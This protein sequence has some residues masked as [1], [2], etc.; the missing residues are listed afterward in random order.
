M[1]RRIKMT[2]QQNN[3]IDVIIPCYNAHK[4]IFRCLCSI[5][6]Q[7]LKDDLKITLVNDCDGSD[8][9]KYVELFKGVL[10]IN[11]I[12]MEKN[13]G[14]GMARQTGINNTTNPIITFIDADDTFTGPYA[15]EVL[16]DALLE[17]KTHVAVFSSFLEERNSVFIEH[18]KD[19]VWMF[20]KL[21]KRDF[22]NKYGIHFFEG[23]RCNEDLSFNKQCQFFSN[24]NE[25]IRAINNTT[26][27]WME[28]ESSIT[29]VNNHEYY[30]KDS[31]WSMLKAWTYSINYA[32]S[33]G[34][35]KE[36]IDKFIKDSIGTAYAYYI[37]IEERRPEFLENA[38]K[39]TVEYY[40]CIFKTV[41]NKITYN[42]FCN[43]YEKAMKNA[44]NTNKLFGCMPKTSFREFVRKLDSEIEKIEVKEK[45]NGKE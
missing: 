1:R 2:D 19:V 5:G 12:T 7:T 8:Y 16:R 28:T 20:G 35:N 17:D 29:R 23:L 32:L 31:Y 10:D 13:G 40:W 22:I 33:K 38:W 14:P 3:K 30:Y 11:I 24:E 44:Y 4:T 36:N 43:A 42:E 34:A 15:L 18:Q 27:Y 26:Y 6:S 41:R 39:A 9:S 37:Q 21:Y 25:K 45:T